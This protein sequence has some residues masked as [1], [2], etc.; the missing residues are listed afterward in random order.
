MSDSDNL[1]CD[2]SFL[3]EKVEA[4]SEEPSGKSN[5]KVMVVD[6]DEEVHRMTSAALRDFTFDGRGLDFVFAS[7]AKEAKLA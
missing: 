7:S 6:D 5:W 1:F 4:P 3:K 2:E